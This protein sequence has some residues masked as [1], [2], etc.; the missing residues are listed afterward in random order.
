VSHK[1]QQFGDD[2]IELL[3][4][5]DN[6]DGTVVS[7]ITTCT[8]TL[9]DDRKDTRIDQRVDRVAAEAL[10]AAAQIQLDSTARFTT[11]DTVE[12]ELDDGTI[13][14]SAV[15]SIDSATLMTLTS[16]L[17]SVVSVGREIRRRVHPSSATVIEVVDGSIFELGDAV[18]VTLDD[19]TLQETTVTQRHEQWITL[20]AG[21]SGAA[22]AGRRIAAKLGADITMTLFGTPAVNDETWGYRGTKADD[23]AGLVEGQKVRVEIEL[24]DDAAVVF[25]TEFRAIVIGRS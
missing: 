13:H 1:L 17:P 3:G 22:S 21:L 11:S 2:L 4:P 14:Q 5:M 16:A 9:Y 20:A 6:S 15:T 19:G 8:A 7:A 10:A 12:I 23:H 18:E 25:T 24:V